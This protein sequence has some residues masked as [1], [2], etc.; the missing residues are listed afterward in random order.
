[1]AGKFKFSDKKRG[2]G[3]PDSW[4]WNLS[5]FFFQTR[6]RHPSL[7]FISPKRA[8]GTPDFSFSDIQAEKRAEGTPV[9]TS[10]LPKTRPRRASVL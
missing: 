9:G 7:T 4:K 10:E 3:A 1:M 2:E 6:R 8:E 5:F